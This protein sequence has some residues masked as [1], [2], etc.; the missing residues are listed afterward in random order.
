MRPSNIETGRVI[1][2]W[3]LSNPLFILKLS[4]TRSHAGCG[5]TGPEVAIAS[6]QF[7]PGGID[8]APAWAVLMRHAS[9]LHVASSPHARF[10]AQPGSCERSLQPC[11]R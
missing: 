2:G 9:F 5:E 6:K 4:V 10:E 1:L 7:F 8:L 3:T 11:G